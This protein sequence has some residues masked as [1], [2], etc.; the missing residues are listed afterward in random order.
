MTLLFPSRTYSQLFL[1]FIPALTFSL[2]FSPSSS[3]SLTF[4][5]F[6][7]TKGKWELVTNGASLKE[8]NRGSFVY[9]D[10]SLCADEKTP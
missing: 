4:F 6:D 10:E 8:R 7:E 2:F 9:P 5:L 3:S 1:F